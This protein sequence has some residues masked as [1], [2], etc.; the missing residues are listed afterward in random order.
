ISLA[1]GYNGAERL[2]G[3]ST[4]TGGAFPGLGSSG[5]RQEK[6]A[7]NNAVA[8]LN[9]NSQTTN[10]APGGFGSAQMTPPT[11]SKNGGP[12]GQAGNA[13]GAGGAFN[14]G[15]AGFL[16][17]FQSELG[18]MASWF[19]PASI[20]GMI[21]GLFAS[22]KRKQ[23]WYKLTDEQKETLLWAG[24]L[25]PVGAFFSIASFFHPYYLDVIGAPIAALTAIGIVSIYKKAKEHKGFSWANIAGFVLLVGTYALHAYYAYS[26]YPVLVVILGILALIVG[27]WWLLP[28]R[29]GGPKGIK[30]K[31]VLT[32][33]ILSVLTGWWALT[34]TISKESAEIPTVGPSLIQTSGNGMGANAGGMGGSANTSVLSYTESH[35]GS[36]T[37][38][39]ATTNSST[40]APYIIAS[41]K[42]VMALGGFNGTDPS[43]SLTKFKELVKEGKVKYF[44]SGGQMGG[45][46]S[47]STGATGQISAIVKWIEANAKTVTLSGSSSST[48]STSVLSNSATSG[49]TLPT[50][51]GSA[52]SMTPPTGSASSN[53]NATA[54]ASTSNG[55]ENSASGMGGQSTTLYD[56]STIKNFN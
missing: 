45:A 28:E 4:G 22:R 54:G 30:I 17:L 8:D 56:L 39:F 40:A 32:V 47:E 49:M 14:I 24:W 31:S 2:L 38:L 33:V 43:I 16:R 10:I 25:I 34:P 19:L 9:T 50:G 23:K 1:F 18:P 11:G 29:F 12:S 41:G 6:Q 46:N 7:L 55:T 35:Q 20:V 13:G 36:A 3:Q 26:Y 37:Y 48:N 5:S 21:V 15:R 27:I 42:S 52:F 53:V 51:S 44:L